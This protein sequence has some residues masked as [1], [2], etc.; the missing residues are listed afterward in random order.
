MDLN[1]I[2]VAVISLGGPLFLWLQNRGNNKRLEAQ[3]NATMQIE[4]E[5]LDGLVMDRSKTL[6]DG[7]IN[8]LEAQAT[9]LRGT[10]ERL[11]KELDE[12]REENAK[13]R[14]SIRELENQADKLDD[15]I[16]QLKVK[17]SRLI[18]SQE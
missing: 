11:E 5:K 16:F 17:L 15:E 8:Q 13:L 4:K 9:K 6:Y 12:E 2:I 14:L 1:I 18:N 3:A 10:I 7:M